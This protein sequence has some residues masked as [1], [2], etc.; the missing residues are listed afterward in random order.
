MWVML[1]PLKLLTVKTDLGLFATVTKNFCP[2]NVTVFVMNI[3]VTAFRHTCIV[4]SQ[5]FL[6]Q[7]GSVVHKHCNLMV[8]YHPQ[9]HYTNHFHKD[10]HFPLKLHLFIHISLEQ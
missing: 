7:A 4:D 2:A 8:P 6:C 1:W 9:Y 3:R 5:E 10:H